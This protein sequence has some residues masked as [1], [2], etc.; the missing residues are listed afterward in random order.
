MSILDYFK[1]LKS[2]EQRLAWRRSDCGGCAPDCG[3]SFVRRRRLVASRLAARSDRGFHSDSPARMALGIPAVVGGR[4]D[5]RRRPFSNLDGRGM[6]RYAPA[7]ARGT[8]GSSS[9]GTSA[10]AAEIKLSAISYQPSGKANRGRPCGR[11]VIFLVAVR[12]R[13]SY[14]NT[15]AELGGKVCGYCQ[16]SFGSA[17]KPGCCVGKKHKP[18]GSRRCTGTSET[19]SETSLALEGSCSRPAGHVPRCQEDASK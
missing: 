4:T 2:P 6:V 17:G 15:S 13:A 16:R 14:M 1:S 5:S 8:T 10:R 9:S 18:R 11:A 7:S 3:I 12:E 19:C